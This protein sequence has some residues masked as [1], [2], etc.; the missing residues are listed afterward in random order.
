MKQPQSQISLA[1]LAALLD[2]P[3]GSLEREA[4]SLLGNLGMDSLTATRLRGALDPMPSYQVLYGLT[5]A[6]AAA[7]LAESGPTQ[8]PTMPAAAATATAAA[9][10][11]L[12]PMQESYV[13]G[14]S[15][16]CPCQV[17]S[18][19]DVIGLD[20]TCFE[21]AV[22]LTA[23]AHPMLHARIVNGTQ[24]MVADA[25]QWRAPLQASVAEAVDLEQRRRQCMGAFQSQ[26]DLHWDIH[27]TRLDAATVRI[28]LLLD[29]LFID[30]TSAMLLC[31]QVTAHYL[32]L[33]KQGIAQ[34]P[35]ATGPAFRDYCDYL[36]H[37]QP[38]QASLDYWNER[39][40]WMPG[41]PQL[42]RLKSAAA[43]GVDFQ[44][45][46]AVLP[47]TQW[48]ALKARACA[49]QVTP[50]ALLLAVFAEV[51]RFYA[52]ETEFSIAITM[53]ERPVARD[54][55]F[56]TVVGEFTN[57]LL[58]PV[59]ARLG[60]GIASRA[61]AI[62]RDLS[63]GLEHGDLSG[64]EVTRMLRKRRAD[65]HLM[66]P[67]VFTSFLG[68]VRSDLDLAD[69][70]TTL[71]YQQTQTPQITLDHQ[72]YELNGELRINWDYD[73]HVYGADL[74]A[75]MLDTFEHL[76]RQVAV[77][78]PRTAVL[79]PATLAL[80]QAMN[81]TAHDFGP[82]APVLLHELVLQSA[83]RMPDAIAVIDQDVVLNYAEVVALARAA[84]VRLQDAGISSGDCV[85]VVMEK[86]WEQ[87][88]ATLGILLT[89]AFYLPL[90]PSDPDERMRSIMALAGAR[91]ALTQEKC[92]AAGR[93]WHQAADATRVTAITVDRALAAGASAPAPV[94][95]DP[96]S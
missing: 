77:N 55:D 41:P 46:A 84:A 18:E 47:Q 92:L 6:Q 10:F 93:E 15:Q 62:H 7:R 49:L 34:L 94:D 91:V 89:G 44:R 21:Q 31:R 64:L 71:H 60:T 75:D 50:S 59:T 86:G 8:A 28:H 87:T 68:I 3:A 66:F 90:N 88:V 67:I 13:I 54:N 17:Y 56:S 38:S 80:R 12:T 22:R 42:P 29:M 33:R 16:D 19:F 4:D 39:C 5:V 95:I 37:K 85:A 40:G 36:A 53:S 43:H 76:L 32:N 65:P 74:M 35:I 20:I 48:S 2:L 72:V 96:A 24:Q 81:Q 51:L 69:C 58:C 25:S 1:A 61:A 57:I 78:V 45:A 11:I 73:A 52:E 30:A 83:T 70:Q 14:A 63:E 82:Q 26:P 27:L 79:P 9:T 23:A